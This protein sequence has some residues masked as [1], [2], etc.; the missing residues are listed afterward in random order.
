MIDWKTR[1]Q[2]KA[3]WVAFVPTLLLLVQVVAN[4]FGYTMDLG[5]MGNNLLDVV[6]VAFVLLSV[7]GVVIDPTTDGFADPTGKSAD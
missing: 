3:F 5:D 2:N 7:L 6:N 4:V 1:I